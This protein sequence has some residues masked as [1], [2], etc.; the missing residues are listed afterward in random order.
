MEPQFINQYV[1]SFEMYKEWANN[2]IGRSAIRNRKKGIRLRVIGSIFSIIMIII[3][4]LLHEF[5]ALLV[6]FIFLIIFMLRLFFIPNRI[7]KKQYDLVMKA[8][9]NSLWTRTTT[10]SDSIVIDEGKSTLRYEY[11][12]IFKMS[13][14]EKYFYLF[15]NVDMVLRIRKDS[16]ILGSCEDLIEFLNSVISNQDKQI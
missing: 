9:N 5:Y 2:P 3:G 13:E 11:S 16:F 10:F 6:G 7:L 4:F 15:M 8:H 12:E 1:V 14:D